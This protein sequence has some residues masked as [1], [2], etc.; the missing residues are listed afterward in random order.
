MSIAHGSVLCCL[1]FFQSWFGGRVFPS[2]VQGLP[3][4][5]TKWGPGSLVMWKDMRGSAVASNKNESQALGTACPG[6][7]SDDDAKGYGTSLNQRRWKVGPH[8]KTGI[9]IH[10]LIEPARETSWTPIMVTPETEKLLRNVQLQVFQVASDR[11]PL[12]QQEGLTQIDRGWRASRKIQQFR[13]RLRGRAQGSQFYGRWIATNKRKM[14]S[15]SSRQDHLCSQ[16][17]NAFAL[18]AENRE[19]NFCWWHQRIL[20]PDG[21]L[22]L[23]LLAPWSTFIRIDGLNKFGWPQMTSISN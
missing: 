13:I 21:P 15:I 12:V 4:S 16:M 3:M 6:R 17:L 11:A 14:G 23:D 5:C 20:F 9:Q 22:K 18:Y 19:F 1:I 10:K 8:D 2:A 7:G